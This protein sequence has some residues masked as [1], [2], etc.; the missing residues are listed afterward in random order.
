MAPMALERRV[1]APPKLQPSGAAS[2]QQPAFVGTGRNPGINVRA[3]PAPAARL[4]MAG[5]R[6]RLSAVAQL[7]RRP[8]ITVVIPCY[9]YGHYLPA[10]V[11][12][13]LGQPD[14]AADVVIVNDASTDGTPPLADALA[15]ADPRVR[16]IHHVRNAGHISTYNEGLATAEGEY[17]VLLSADDLL[18][19]GALG[20][21]TALMDAHPS[22]GMVYGH[23]VR[24]SGRPPDKPRTRV[25]AWMLWSG[26]DWLAERFTLGRNCILSPEVVMRTAIQ[27]EIGGYRPE[28]PHSGDLEMWLR[29]ACIADIGYVGGVDQAWYRAHDTNMHS[30]V[31][32][33]QELDS[34]AVDFRERLRAFELAADH[35]EARIPDTE[36]LLTRARRALAVEALT[37]ALRSCY[38]GVAESWPTDELRAVA[39]EI[40]PDASRLAQWRALSIHER[41]GTGWQRRNPI[42]VAHEVALRTRDAS[43]EWRWVQAGR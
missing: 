22:V 10:C 24:F 21:A 25:S 4:A 15:A 19:P 1:S 8:T 11:A 35:A 14:V 13:V 33:T 3:R 27:R 2:S 39:L 36:R 41:V 43:R 34:L 31:F 16:V 20:R 17:V 7:T 9:N 38:W 23:A 32:R 12:T 26:S 42:S 5:S 40:Y 18:T 30:A 28:L 29:A 37:L 6:G